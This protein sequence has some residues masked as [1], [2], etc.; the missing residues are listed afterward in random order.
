MRYNIEVRTGAFS[1][2][3]HLTKTRN[4]MKR[5]SGV[6]LPIFSLPGAYGCGTFGESAYHWVDSLA[7]GGFSYWQLLPFGITDEHNSPYMSY[8]SFAGNPFFI[9]PNILYEQGLISEAEEHAARVEEPYLCAWETLR[10]RRLSLLRKAAAR[11]KDRS[12]VQAF[13]NT[14]P[15]VAGTCEFLALKSANGGARWQDWSVHTL[16]PD[17]L[18]AWQFIQYEFHRQWSMLHAYASKRGVRVIGD[19]PFYVSID[20]YD[21]Y[22]AP[23]LFLLDA[24]GEPTQVAGVPPDYFCEDGQ[25]WGNPIYNFSEMKKDGYARWRERLSYTLSL[26]DGVRID[27]FRA[28]SAY[29]SI[30]AGAK[31]AKEG[32]W[33]RG[34]REELIDA[35]APLAADRLILAENLGMIDEDT[36]ALLAYSGYP[37]MAVFQFGF[38]GNPC[39]PHLPHSYERNLFAYTGTH[40]NNTLLGFLFELD[41]STRAN[42]LDYL[43]HPSDPVRATVRAL[44]MSAADTV[45]F[46]VQDLLAFGADTRVN[47]PGN[48][49]GNWRY[50]L[51]RDQLDS[52]DW[53]ELG[54]MNKRYAR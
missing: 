27:H 40:D 26:F 12:A 42:V 50:R 21:V 16:D 18:F 39:S 6:L 48:T 20:S 45:I 3:P 13:L 53:Y 15:H 30:P 49:T 5:H 17:E 47:T 14:H 46:P 7:V 9:D 35:F 36:Q 37:G 51:T 34:P 44:M 43:G 38:D 41:E 22:S 24:R 33:E 8:S 32:H 52:V 29:W 2:S 1:V 25:Y 10:E 23:H 4:A 19:I 54:R 11:V 28:I 31:S